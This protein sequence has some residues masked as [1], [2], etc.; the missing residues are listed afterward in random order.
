[1]NEHKQEHRL[2]KIL[3]P[4]YLFIAILPIIMICAGYA[5]YLSTEVTKN[6]KPNEN[7]QKIKPI[8]SELPIEDKKIYITLP[9]SKKIE[10]LLE[11][12]S[13]DSSIWRLVSKG[14]AISTEYIP[15]PIKIPE[16]A[17]RTNKSDT[18]RSVRSDIEQLLKNMF[19]DAAKT[20][21]QIVILSGYRP[22]SM[23]ASIF[24]GAVNR[25]GEAIAN[26]YIAKP[27]ESEHQTAL[28]I[29]VTSASLE[30]YLDACFG[31]TSD[32]E[33]LKENSFRYGFILRY[34]KDKEEITG[35]NY[36]PWHFRYVGVE[37]ATALYES[38]LTLDEAWPYL[39]E[40][41]TQL[42]DTNRI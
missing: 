41:L 1:M 40:A 5:Y 15:S 18:E 38:G 13:L 7:T 42:K 12:Y 27:G 39:M 35:Y 6:P 34:P 26:K 10:A 23:Q 25:D 29:D 36:E 37:L 9:G 19:E 33:W 11:D 17:T 14:N 30:C 2:S 24:N 31:E 3:T 20:G 16:V 21:R 22:A 8:T 4:R 32:G 28:A